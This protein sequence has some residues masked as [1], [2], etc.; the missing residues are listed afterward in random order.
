MQK[1]Y[2]LYAGFARIDISP[3][4]P[5]GMELN[6]MPRLYHGALG[7]MDPLYARACYLKAGKKACLIVICDTVLIARMPPFRDDTPVEGLEEITGAI[8]KATGL[9]KKNIHFA[10]THCHS[11]IGEVMKTVPPYM[12]KVLTRYQLELK[13]KL[14]KLGLEA[15]KNRERVM[16]GHGSKEVKGIAGSRRVKLSDGLVVTGWGEGPTPPPGVR[17]V[18]RGVKDDTLGAVIFKNMKGK[19]I[20]SIINFNSH[21][22]L[23]PMLYFSPE[24]AGYTAALL[25]KKMPGSISV[26]TN[27]AEGDISLCANTPACP[28]DH[29]RMKALYGSE[30]RRLSGLMVKTIMEIARGLKYRDKAEIRTVGA[31]VKVKNSLNGLAEE[32]I[33]AVTINDL[34]LVFENEEIVVDYALQLKKRSPFKDTFVIGM[35]GYRNYYLTTDYQREEGGYEPKY[36]MENGSLDRVVDST[37]KILNRCKGR[38]K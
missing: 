15:C 35:E 29:G 32:K 21:I 5:R 9:N 2:P 36:M 27:G 13:A 14:I 1:Q 38:T 24:L 16:M 34:A 30:M 18:D 7:V 19:C 10:A 6:G 33:N 17:I 37:V 20:G 25:D 3:K 22:H 4:E 12:R 31:V 28:S 11:S 26:Y 8:A 23:Y